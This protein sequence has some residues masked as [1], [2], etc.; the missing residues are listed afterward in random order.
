MITQFT[1]KEIQMTYI[2]IKW[3]STW[4]IIIELRNKM[5]VRY[6]FPG[7]QLTKVK[8]LPVWWARI[9]WY[10]LFARQ[11]GNIYRNHKCLANVPAIQI[12]ITF[13]IDKITHVYKNLHTRLFNRRL[14]KYSWF[15][16]QITVL[17]GRE[18]RLLYIYW[19]RNI[20]KIQC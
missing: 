11:L 15:I 18:N 19:H 1:E 6:Y 5:M 10:G 2:H 14:V 13:P 4:I 8:K 20:F 12:Q 16:Q 7:I 3:F 9:K 17:C